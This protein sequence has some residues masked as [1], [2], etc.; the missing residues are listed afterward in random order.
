MHGSA[1]PT[2]RCPPHKLAR[3]CRLTLAQIDLTR[4]D[5][6][7]DEFREKIN[8]ADV[9]FVNNFAFGA[10]VNQE[11]K[12]RRKSGRTPLIAPCSPWCLGQHRFEWAKEGAKI[13]S[14]FNFAPM[15]FRISERTMNGSLFEPCP[16]DSL[17]AVR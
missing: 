2:A 3:C 11:L 5:F 16:L 14:S 12:V 15:N 8:Q 17:T 1:R 7:D 4:G 9:I 10:Q 13:V 6:L